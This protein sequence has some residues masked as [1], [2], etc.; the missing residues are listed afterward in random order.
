VAGLRLVT[1]LVPG[2]PLGLFELIARV[3]GPDTELICD[4]RASGPVPGVL[5]PFTADLA[6]VGFMCAPP[7][8]RL[9][10]S[11]VTSPLDLLGIA[12]VFDD[13]RCGGRPMY[14]ADVVV[15]AS[16]AA[17][18]VDDLRG[19][20]LGV[21]DPSSL[22]GLTALQLHLAERGD[23]LSFFGRVVVTGSHDDSLDA[24]ERG[25]IDVASIDST[26]LRA[27]RRSGVH[28]ARSVRVVAS[29]GPHPVQPVV[30][31]SG[32]DASHRQ[33]VVETL[34]GLAATDDGRRSLGRYDCLGFEPI[35]PREYDLLDV[36]LARLTPFDVEVGA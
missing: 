14:M 20:T 3:L 28:A 12:P 9:R 10:R 35:D 13:P 32:L 36:R 11:A 26:T 16:D 30:V 6:D 22:S 15:R 25:E 4:D 8:L 19:A 31:R 34:Q 17:S 21:N 7:F 18:G 33:H 29:L 23:D 2:L 1:Y 27:R 5:D 24:L